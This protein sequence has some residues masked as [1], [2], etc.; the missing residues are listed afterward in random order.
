MSI[1]LLY[2]K[3]V[4]F[5]ESDIMDL[6]IEKTK[7]AIRNAFLQLRSKKPLEKITIKELSALA[8]IN[9][10]TFYLHYHDIYDLSETLERDVVKSCLDNIEHPE[11]V[12]SDIENFL[13][14]LN[15]SV[16]ANEQLIKILFEGNR[17]NSFTEL[18][19]KELYTMIYNYYPDY[20]PSIESRMLTSFLIYGAY[21]TYFKYTDQGIQPVLQ[22]IESFSGGIVKLHK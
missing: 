13:K 17:S 21:H 7:C 19:E 22:L 14:C 20:K 6:R 1:N 16:V 11:E 9:K 12:I 8:N 4:E 2:S 15:Q 3:K 5:L 18:F 10:A